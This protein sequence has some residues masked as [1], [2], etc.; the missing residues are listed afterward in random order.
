MT[1]SSSCHAIIKP[2]KKLNQI[3]YIDQL[4]EFHA[5]FLLF[6]RSLNEETYFIGKILV[7]KLHHTSISIHDVRFLRLY[8]VMQNFILF[9]YIL[10]ALR[11]DT[12][13]IWM[14]RPT[15]VYFSANRFPWTKCESNRANKTKMLFLF[16]NLMKNLIKYY[17]RYTQPAL[18]WN[19]R[20][21]YFH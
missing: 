6:P 9:M 10:E 5:S 1:L 15:R 8:R 17:I 18:R 16:W 4:S 19:E 7:K 11:R 2:P 21:A 14:M 13:L 20:H 12:G 3:S